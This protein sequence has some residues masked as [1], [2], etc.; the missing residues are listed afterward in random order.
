MAASKHVKIDTK[1]SLARSRGQGHSLVSIVGYRR[2]A[3]P[4]NHR[5]FNPRF[6]YVLLDRVL[7]IGYVSHPGA[8]QSLPPH[9]ESH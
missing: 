4:G 7:A 1:G 3:N 5:H 8:S 6:V 9:G 2:I